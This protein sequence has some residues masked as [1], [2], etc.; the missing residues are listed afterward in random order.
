[1][2]DGQVVD[3]QVVDGWM[4]RW[5]LE[6]GGCRPSTTARNGKTSW[7]SVRLEFVEGTAGGHLPSSLLP[8][9]IVKLW[10][11]RLTIF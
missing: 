1:M 2:V 5:G 10:S 8:R 11:W 6:I 9:M 7:D 4:V 3:G